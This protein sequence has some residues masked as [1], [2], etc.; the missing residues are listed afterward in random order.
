MNV[1]LL[2]TAILFV[3]VMVSSYVP[4]VGLDIARTEADYLHLAMALL[5]VLAGA[6]AIREMLRDRRIRRVNSSSEKTVAMPHERSFPEAIVSAATAVRTGFA[7][8]PLVMTLVSILILATP[9]ALRAMATRRNWNEFTDIDWIII[10]V[11]EAPMLLIAAVVV[12]RRG[13][14]GSQ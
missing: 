14:S 2:L 10:G 8:R 4:K 5:M 12:F 7:R 6:L 13:Q 3:F 1:L 11:A 9:L